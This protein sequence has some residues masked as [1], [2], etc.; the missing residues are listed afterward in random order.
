MLPFPEPDRR[1]ILFQVVIVIFFSLCLLGYLMEKKQIN[2][3]QQALKDLDV[4]HDAL[5]TL[6]AGLKDY[7]EIKNEN[8]ICQKQNDALCWQHVEL[9]WTDLTFS[10]CLVRLNGL[11]ETRRLFIPIEFKAGLLGAFKDKNPGEPVNKIKGSTSQKVSFELKG[12]CLCPC[13]NR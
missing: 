11:Y 4:R 1:Q 9:N 2:V 7:L 12:Y 8:L 3:L 10:E 5:I 13:Q 6:E